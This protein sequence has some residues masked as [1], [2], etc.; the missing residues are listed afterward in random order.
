MRVI[1]SD[2]VFDFHLIKKNIVQEIQEAYRK[3]SRK[4][5]DV[6]RFL[7]LIKIYEQGTTI[8][9]TWLSEVVDG[10]KIKF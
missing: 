1:V 4:I 8:L 7:C 2:E 9:T 6:I 3:Q 10:W 5:T